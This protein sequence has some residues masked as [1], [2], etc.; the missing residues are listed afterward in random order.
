M[1]RSAR[2]ATVWD[3][4]STDEG[5]VLFFATTHGP[6]THTGDHDPTLNFNEGR[7][8][9]LTLRPELASVE[10]LPEQGTVSQK[11]DEHS[12]IARADTPTRP[13]GRGLGSVQDAGPPRRR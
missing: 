4:A 12:L 2:P 13:G 11:S 10:G 8:G 3:L 6:I 7:L 1:L 9:V 5:S